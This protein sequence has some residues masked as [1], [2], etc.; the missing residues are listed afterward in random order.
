MGSHKTLT[1]LLAVAL[2]ACFGLGVQATWAEPPVSKLTTV[3]AFDRNKFEHTEGFGT[4]FVQSRGQRPVLYFT[5]A[6]LI[7]GTPGLQKIDIGIA[8]VPLP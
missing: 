8:G 2:T 5:N 3:D 6:G 4:S 7:F 1:K